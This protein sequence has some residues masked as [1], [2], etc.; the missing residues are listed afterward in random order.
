MASGVSVANECIDAFHEIKLGHKY[1]YIV[2]RLSSDLKEVVVC[3]KAELTETYEDFLTYIRN[4]EDTCFYAVYD[5][6]Y[7]IN[8]MPRQKLVFFLCAPDNATPKEKMLYTSS[9]SAF[10]KKLIGI[11]VDV[12]AND[13]SDFDFNDIVTKCCEKSQ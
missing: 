12:Q 9:K 13:F 11:C 8:D 4:L 7:V 10:R 5:F 3:K 2:Y 6:D 1:K